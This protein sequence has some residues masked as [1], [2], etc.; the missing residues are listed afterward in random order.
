[1]TTLKEITKD[2]FFQE[3]HYKAFEFEKIH[4][5]TPVILEERKNVQERL[6]YL[7][8]I[9]YPVIQ[10]KGWGIHEHYSPEH[11][12]S[13]IDIDNPFIPNTLQS[14]WLHYGKSFDEIKLYKRLTSDKEKETFIQHIRLQ[15]IIFNHG[16]LNSNDF[17]IGTWLVFG[18]P[19]GSIWDRDYLSRKLKKDDSFSRNLYDHL[20]RLDSNYYFNVNKKIRNVEE[21]KTHTELASFLLTDDIKKY[22]ILGKDFKPNDSRITSDKIVTTIIS[23][24]EMLYQIYNLFKHRF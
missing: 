16:R 21:F 14:I 15:V 7:H 10:Q 9:L 22:F 8:D 20:I 23:E 17:G 3:E 19:H 24:F 6:L 12:V 18:K 4:R 11:I 5:N 1:M 13:G 2:H